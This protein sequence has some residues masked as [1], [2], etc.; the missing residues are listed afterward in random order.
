[1]NLGKLESGEVTRRA[2]FSSYAWCRK[3]NTK[4]SCLETPGRT[5]LFMILRRF[6]LKSWVFMAETYF[7]GILYV[8]NVSML[9]RMREGLL[10]YR[11]L[12]RVWHVDWSTRCDLTWMKKM[13]FFWKLIFSFKHDLCMF[14]MQKSKILQ[15]EELGWAR[16]IAHKEHDKDVSYLE[17]TWEVVYI[18]YTPNK[19]IN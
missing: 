5:E 10:F 17:Y 13:I 9:K 1:M 2:S 3:S 16:E 11:L 4:Y 7:F 18:D 15:K 19:K 12:D 8:S 14:S 6:F